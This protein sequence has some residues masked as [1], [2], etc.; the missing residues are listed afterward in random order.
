MDQEQ[1]HVVLIEG[2]IDELRVIVIDADD[3]LLAEFVFHVM[4]RSFHWNSMWSRRRRRSSPSRARRLRWLTTQD[5]SW[6][7]S[8][9]LLGTLQCPCLRLKSTSAANILSQNPLIEFQT[10]PSS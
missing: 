5:A 10:K 6:R 8:L 3:L 2:A 4:P 9:H 7:F 1:S